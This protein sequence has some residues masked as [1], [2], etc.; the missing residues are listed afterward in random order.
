MDIADWIGDFNPL[1]GLLLLP[2]KHDV[3]STLSVR[4]PPRASACS[5]RLCLPSPR[6]SPRLTH[7]RAEPFPLPPHPNMIH[8]HLRRHRLGAVARASLLAPSLAHP[9]STG[10]HAADE[11]PACLS[12]PTRSPSSTLFLDRASPA[13]SSLP[14]ELSPPRYATSPSPSLRP[15]HDAGLP[16]P[17]LSRR[18]ASLPLASAAGVGAAA[19]V[20]F[21][22]TQ[23]RDQAA[24]T[25]TALILA[26]SHDHK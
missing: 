26:T 6:V 18:N 23:D 10:R 4:P 8:P 9:S 2:K 11:G 19:G 16:E 7:S 20:P 24:R 12:P 13:A 14:T 21:R 15:S 3:L 17:S 5:T 1:A 22:P 25:S